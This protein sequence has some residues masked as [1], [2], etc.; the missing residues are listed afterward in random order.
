M[1]LCDVSLDDH[2]HKDHDLPK[3][4]LVSAKYVNVTTIGFTFDMK[5]DDK[6]VPDIEIST[7]KEQWITYKLIPGGYLTEMKPNFKYA[8]V[9]NT[10]EY[11]DIRNGDSS[12][13]NDVKKNEGHKT[14][15]DDG[16]IY[17]TGMRLLS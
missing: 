1:I 4:K 2:E 11:V 8:R 17:K 5:L 3:V 6:A 16:K 14:C 9:E 7:D 13:N 12:I 15:M 10:E